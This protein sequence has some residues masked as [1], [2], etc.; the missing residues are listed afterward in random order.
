MEGG[1]SAPEA[2][3]SFPAT[4]CEEGLLESNVIGLPLKEEKDFDN[5]KWRRKARETSSGL[6]R[7]GVKCLVAMHVTLHR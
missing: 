2:S 7:V 3:S 5:G 4:V 6:R 1:H